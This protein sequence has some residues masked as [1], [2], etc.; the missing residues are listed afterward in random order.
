MRNT[1]LARIGTFA[2][3]AGLASAPLSA[4]WQFTNWGM[5][6]DELKSAAKAHGITMTK[7]SEKERADNGPDIKFTTHSVLLMK[8]EITSG[9]FQFTAFFE[10][11]AL[12]RA[13]LDVVRAVTIVAAA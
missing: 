2:I 4:D 13:N 7:P 10:L 8:A 11:S 5:S 3:I 1:L 12:S 6:P 9:N